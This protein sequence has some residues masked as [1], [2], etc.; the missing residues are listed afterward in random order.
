MPGV[1]RRSTLPAA[2]QRAAAH[3]HAV[4]EAAVAANDRRSACGRRSRRRVQWRRDSPAMPSG[5]C[6][7][8]PSPG[9]RPSTMPRG[10]NGNGAAP[11]HHMRGHRPRAVPLA[12][13]HSSGSAPARRW[14]AAGTRVRY[15][16]P[17]DCAARSPAAGWRRSAA[18]AS[19]HTQRSCAAC[20]QCQQRR[21]CR[22]R[23]AATRAPAG[24]IR[25]SPP[26]SACSAA[27]SGLQPGR[28]CRGQ[29][30]A[31]QRQHQFATGATQ[32][33]AAAWPLRCASA[34]SAGSA[35]RNCA[36]VALVMQ[37]SKRVCCTS[38]RAA[39]CTQASCSRSLATGQAHRAPQLHRRAVADD[40]TDGQVCMRAR[41][42]TARCPAAA[43]T[44]A[45]SAARST[46]PCTS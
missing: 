38:V 21:A 26:H 12:A 7:T 18:H 44:P 37:G 9:S 25:P 14:R 46:K 6:S 39:S 30:V 33:A 22:E 8:T 3:A 15:C 27:A 13:L 2:R 34:A 4:D 11:I 16:T 20:A 5:N 43:T 36:L 10:G 17:P 24:R 1:P 45:S 35:A 19:R 32:R 28:G 40:Q 29:L 42:S 41:S 23:R 31:R